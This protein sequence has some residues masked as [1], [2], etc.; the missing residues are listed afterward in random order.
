MSG[1]KI[2]DMKEIGSIIRCTDSV[3]FNGQ[4]VESMKVSTKMIKSMGRVHFI[5]LTEGNMWEGG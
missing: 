3:K 5:G 1:V 4:T 2:E